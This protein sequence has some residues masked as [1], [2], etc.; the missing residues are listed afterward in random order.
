M[1]RSH[2]KG[3]FYS[4]CFFSTKFSHYE[5][6]IFVRNCCTIGHVLSTLH[7]FVQG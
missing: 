2:M 5:K 1:R 7:I 4:K 6:V 3:V